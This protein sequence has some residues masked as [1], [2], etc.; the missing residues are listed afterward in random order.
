MRCVGVM[1]VA[2]HP[3]ILPDL[4]LEDVAIVLHGDQ[5]FGTKECLN[6][7]ILGGQIAIGSRMDNDQG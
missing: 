6:H 1:P 3:D 5:K 4:A 2:D 7:N